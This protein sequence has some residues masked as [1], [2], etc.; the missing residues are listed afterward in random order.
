MPTSRQDLLSGEEVSKQEV[1][2]EL[3]LRPAE[4]LEWLVRDAGGRMW[5]ADLVETTG[6]SGSSVSRYLGRL[7]SEGTVD[8]VQIGRRK[9]VGV[10]GG[11]P[12]SV[13]TSDG[14]TA[15]H[16][17]SSWSSEVESPA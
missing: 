10:P 9:L 4:F 5:Q 17:T 6:W 11:L 15:D 7:E 12:E 1:H 13:P 3:G 16:S 2:I 8:R 14:P